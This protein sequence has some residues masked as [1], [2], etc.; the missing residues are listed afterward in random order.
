MHQNQSP[1]LL[2]IGLTLTLIFAQ[3]GCQ[4]SVSGVYP[5]LQ[6]N[7][8]HS[9]MGNDLG[10]KSYGETN[11]LLIYPVAI[12][13]H[14][15]DL[16]V[17][18][19]NHHGQ[20]YH[21]GRGDIAAFDQ[22]GNPLNLPDLP[23]VL[24]ELAEEK[25]N[26]AKI[27]VDTAELRYRAINDPINPRKTSMGPETGLLAPARAVN[28]YQA[29]GQQIVND[30]RRRE[31]SKLRDELELLERRY[32]RIFARIQENWLEEAEVKTADYTQ[33]VIRVSLSELPRGSDTISLQVF[34]GKDKHRIQLSLN[35]K[36][37]GETESPSL[38]SL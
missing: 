34:T 18:A 38:A 23:Q 29:S 4:K 6:P 19:E 1:L 17:I 16:L 31:L 32:E 21:F 10:I 27:L 24:L 5:E 12:R 33:G 11:N 8:E 14:H 2:G 22:E 7:Q 15:I 35:K 36:A 3:P 9:R 30:R 13:K 20:P 28:P 26:A 37:P 25:Q